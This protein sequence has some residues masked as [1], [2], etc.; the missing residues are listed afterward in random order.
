MIGSFPVPKR[1]RAV[2]RRFELM[3][4]TAVA[5]PRS[6]KTSHRREY[7][8]P[9]YTGAT[10]NSLRTW[11]ITQLQTAFPIIGTPTPVRHSC[12][13]ELTDEE[14]AL[15]QNKLNSRPRKCLDHATPND[16]FTAP[17]PIALAA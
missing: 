8:F 9:L 15:V 13:A 16:I 7:P 4:F 6:Q 11:R 12:F 10:Q 14:V 17:S 2:F 1:P 3:E 5:R